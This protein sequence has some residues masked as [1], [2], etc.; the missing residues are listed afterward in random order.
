MNIL[1]NHLP[2]RGKDFRIPMKLAGLK[3]KDHLLWTWGCEVWF[4][5]PEYFPNSTRRRRGIFLGLSDLKL[6]YVVLDLE[7]G[8]IIESRDCKFMEKSFPFRE[9][10]RPCEINLDYDKLPSHQPPQQIT[11]DSDSVIVA[12]PVLPASD[13]PLVEAPLLPVHGEQIV[14]DDESKVPAIAGH[15]SKD[16]N[17]VS[18][19]EHVNDEDWEGQLTPISLQWG[20]DSMDEPTLDLKN[21]P[22]NTTT[23]TLPPVPE[24]DDSDFDIPLDTNDLTDTIIL[25]KNPNHDNSIPYS[26]S[27]P[28]LD[29]STLDELTKTEI[30]HTT[31]NLPTDYDIKTE[32]KI[33]EPPLGTKENTPNE[34]PPGKPLLENGGD[35]RKHTLR[36]S[37]RIENDKIKSK[38]IKL[39][40]LETGKINKI[41]TTYDNS[42]P[43]NITVDGKTNKYRRKHIRINV[44][45]KDKNKNNTTTTTPNETPK[46]TENASPPK[47]KKRK[48]QKFLFDPNKETPQP[49]PIK[50]LGT[51]K[52]KNIYW[53]IQEIT[54]VRKNEEFTSDDG[55]EY[56]VIW[57]P[58]KDGTTLDYTWEPKQNLK[59]SKKTIN[60]FFKSETGLQRKPLVDRVHAERKLKGKEMRRRKV[61]TKYTTGTG[62]G[63]CGINEEEYSFLTAPILDTSGQLPFWTTQGTENH[64]A[65]E[66]VEAHGS[67]PI[68]LPPSYQ[69]HVH[70]TPEDISLEDCLNIA[71]GAIEELIDP[72]TITVPKNRKQA[73]EHDYRDEF[74]KAEITELAGIHQHGTFKEVICPPDRTPITCRWVYDIKKLKNGQIEKFKAR[75]VCHG[76]KQKPGID[77][78]KTFS[79]TTQIRTFRVFV[80]TAIQH[81]WD[82]TAYDISNAYLNSYLDTDIYMK[83]PDGYPSENKGTVIKL[84]KGLYGLKQ[85]GRL[86][87]Q[88]LFETLSELGFQVC[89]SEASV[90]FKRDT[91]EGNFVIISFVDDLCLGGASKKLR[92]Q[93]EDLLKSR[94]LLKCLGELS[95]FVGIGIDYGKKLGLRTVKLHQEAYWRRA[96]KKF[97]LENAKISKVPAVGYRLSKLSCPT[98]EE[99]KAKI[100]YE[101]ISATGT[102]LY[103]AVC[104]RPDIFFAVT[105][106]ARFNSNPGQ[107]HVKASKQLFQYLKGT[108][109]DGIHYTQDKNF[110]GK[111]KIHCYVD[112]DWAGCPDTRRSTMGYVIMISNGPVSWKSKMMPMVALSSCEAEFMALS[113]VCREL[114]WICRFYD[115]IGI[116]YEVPHIFCDSQSAI[117]WAEDPIQHQR[118]KHIEIKYYYCRD[119]VSNDK[120][121]LFYLCSTRQLADVMTKPTGKQINDRLKPPLMGQT[122]Q[123]F[124]NEI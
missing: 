8:D 30:I 62:T 14:E 103:G 100:D 32:T 10:L 108:M 12:P 122:Y 79:S 119:V 88:T 87:Q 9:T 49:V 28:I 50:E 92:K 72:D 3:L 38:L 84:I 61:K 91:K 121:R 24:T 98:T 15:D 13:E 44:G 81:N 83:W 71:M 60:D 86:W 1:R 85:S 19:V 113:E 97:N 53:E 80:A 96:I 63:L 22:H 89:K 35:E 47:Q 67:K 124:I 58:L 73:M 94:F 75:L 112:S 16:N 42:N 37:T 74:I 82:I 115:E 41:S 106:L 120:A 56:K 2:H 52:E 95:Q 107:D 70:Y 43:L 77:F 99:K 123:N 78:N 34:S 17:V 76:F 111:M 54:D 65:Y 27:T 64:E 66:A 26:P 31:D 57:K 33:G 90:L 29:S 40:K 101:Y 45:K 68:E 51:K 39:N 116:D 105:Q 102:Q 110:N 118:N 5:E 48:Y 6:G 109:S 104:T 69:E 46:T 25:P 7:T 55:L 36:R 21:L 117:A 18:P 23:Q 114:M 11:L 4:S 59:Y 20:D 93:V